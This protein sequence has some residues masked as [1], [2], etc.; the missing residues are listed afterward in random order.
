MIPEAPDFL[1]K[2]FPLLEPRLKKLLLNL[3]FHRAHA[4]SADD[5]QKAVP[6]FKLEK[7]T[8]APLRQEGIRVLRLLG[9]PIC[10]TTQQGFWLEFVDG[11]ELKE[12]IRSMRHRITSVMETVDALEKTLEKHAYQVQG[13][14]FDG[15]I[16][17]DRGTEASMDRP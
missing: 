4:R 3:P 8:Q 13:D 1:N 10:S 12:T 9:W 14:L 7:R 11:E 15:E 5:L 2:E 17:D 6:E 16:G